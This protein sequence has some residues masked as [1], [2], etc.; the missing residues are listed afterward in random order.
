M[1]YGESRTCANNPQNHKLSIRKSKEIMQQSK[2]LGTNNPTLV[3]S[4]REPAPSQ[5]T[6]TFIKRSGFA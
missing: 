1:Q 5:N 6:N 3:N 4:A 2:M